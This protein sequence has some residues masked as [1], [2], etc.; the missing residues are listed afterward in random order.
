MIDAEQ[1]YFQP[2]ISRITLEMMRKYNKEK[3][4]VFNTYQCYLKDAF[5]E[6]KF[7]HEPSSGI[8]LIE[9]AFL[10]RRFVLIWSKRSVRTSTSVASWSVAPT[11][12][13][14]GHVPPLST[15]PIRRIP[16]TKLPPTC[17]TKL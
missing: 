11:L 14:R 10:S 16:R 5:V 6:V 15:T 4:V 7:Q 12:N 2:A 13:R 1:T 17:I 9:G 8:D 3:A